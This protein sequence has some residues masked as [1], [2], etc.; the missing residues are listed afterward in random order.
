LR[1]RAKA[2]KST[3]FCGLS[4]TIAARSFRDWWHLQ[5]WALKPE[6]QPLPY[7]FPTCLSWCEALDEKLGTRRPL[8]E[9]ARFNLSDPTPPGVRTAFGERL[10]MIPSIVSSKG[11][12]VKASIRVNVK[13]GSVPA[14]DQAVRKMRG[15][16]ATP[17]GEEF[18]EAVDLWRHARELAN[19]FY[20]KWD[21]EPPLEWLDARA[22][23]MQLVRQVLHGSRTY[24][25]MAQVRDA[26]AHDPRVQRWQA[27]EPTFE[28]NTVPVWIC[29]DVLEYAQAWGQ[30]RG[31]LVW[32]EHR[33]VGE[34]LEDDFG[35]SYFGQ[36]GRTRDGRSIM[37]HE[38]PAAVSQSAVSRG[39]N[40]QR[41]DQNLILNA[42]PL[43]TRYEQIFGRTHRQ[44]QEA[45]VVTFDILVTVA[46]QLAGFEQARRDAAYEQQTTGQSQKLCLADVTQTG[47]LRA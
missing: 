47:A 31:G 42:T 19:G 21:P 40:L 23:F 15:T 41:Y 11:G 8:G 20:Y 1:K 26:Y 10:R 16:W 34:R 33:A 30:L 22:E 6:L 5:Q 37:H 29:D 35:L 17:G 28:P 25:T 12:E 38:G 13:F 2:H 24:D 4:G 32:V 9:L 43:G 45:D 7:D 39:F 18:T 44:M 46:E 36:Q 27:V 14:I 3:I